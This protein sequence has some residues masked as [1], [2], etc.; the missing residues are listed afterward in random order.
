MADTPTPNDAAKQGKGNQNPG[1][2][3]PGENGSGPAN[4]GAG[5]KSGDK[6]VSM[7]QAELDA[8]IDKRLARD[9]EK[10]AVDKEKLSDAEKALQEVADLREQL[11]ES[12]TARL[13]TAIA[14]E[15]GVPE[16]LITGADEDTM[17]STATAIQEYA[18]AAQQQS[19]GPVVS[20]VGQDG[21]DEPA[22]EGGWDAESLALITGDSD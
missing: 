2:E 20:S 19:T 13:R 16:N 18:G 10:H 8:L 6:T 3:K 17:R 15:T 21:G 9:R 14:A 11:A 22:G 7:T 12:N 5:D 1:G 4:D